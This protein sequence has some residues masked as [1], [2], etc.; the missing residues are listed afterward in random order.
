[1]RRLLLIAIGAL[2]PAA[3]LA[4]AVAVSPKPETVAVTIYRNPDRSADDALD[5]GWVGG[6][7]LITERRT[8]SIPA[9]DAV[10]RFEGVAGGML[11]QS[12]IVTGLPDGIVEKNRDAWLLSPASLLDASLGKRV[13]IRR[14]SRATGVVTETEAVIRSG[15]GGAVVLETPAGIEALRCTGLPETLVYDEVP[16]GLSARPTLSLRTRS[17][18]AV[19][20]T[21]TLSYLASGFDWDANY[22]ADLSPDGRK[23]DLFAWM[24]LANGDETGFVDA[25][26]Q[27]VAG[28]VNREEDDDEVELRREPINLQCWAQGTTTSDLREIQP[29]PP[30][31]MMA[32]N[33]DIMVTGSRISQS[34]LMATSPVAVMTAE[35]LEL[36]DLKLYRI[37]EPVTVAANSQKQVALLRREGVP[38]R[39]V[40]RASFDVMDGFEEEQEAPRHFLLATNKAANGLGLALPSGGVSLFTDHGGR[41]ILLGEG[42]FPQKAVGEEVEIDF[43]TASMLG[44]SFRFVCKAGGRADYELLLSNSS[45]APIDFEAQLLFNE[46]KAKAR[47]PKGYMPVWKTSVPANGTRT[48]RFSAVIADPYSGDARAAAGCS[49]PGRRK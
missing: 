2:T 3:A 26:A 30:P 6:Y 31:P 43:G 34:N 13:H 42:V 28:K 46:I 20:A 33:E 38:V 29:P 5:L 22:I 10:I 14:T 12:A 17:R 19:R 44:T 37:P 36:G 8:V 15:A 16:E 45:P 9:G 47:I 4:Q 18:E 11:P 39:H 32:P 24:T 21:L 48:L 1:V 25:E 7:A 40:Y 23:I 35:Q 27:A 41:P 49:R